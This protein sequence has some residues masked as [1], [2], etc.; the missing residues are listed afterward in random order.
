MNSKSFRYSIKYGA[1]YGAWLTEKYCRG[2][3][4]FFFL[5]HT[6][7]KSLQ[8]AQNIVHQNFKFF[9][10]WPLLAKIE[11]F[12]IT[13]V[14]MPWDSPSKNELTRKQ[15]I[16][17]TCIWSLSTNF[18]FSGRKSQN[19]LKLANKITHFTIQ[20][21]SKNLTY[22]RN[23]NSF[24]VIKNILPQHSQEYISDWC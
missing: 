11:N 16:K 19:Q 14:K 18:R 12:K 4:L 2:A 3:S 1:Q 9:K 15:M 5:V 24:N 8:G 23:L 6:C 10:P 7:T 13:L 22:F 20:F 17:K 21:C